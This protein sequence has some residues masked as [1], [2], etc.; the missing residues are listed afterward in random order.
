MAEGSQDE[1]GSLFEGMVL[2]TPQFQSND[3]DDHPT[4]P[5]PPAHP[6]LSPSVPRSS[7]SLNRQTS[8]P[9]DENLFSDLTLMPAPT[10]IQQVPL[11]SDAHNPPLVHKSTS[12]V[13]STPTTAGG[14]R[15][16]K[17]G[18]VRIGYARESSFT[19]VHLDPHPTPS[20]DHSSSLADV[21]A[22]AAAV[23]VAVAQVPASMSSEV[24]SSTP[25]APLESLQNV[26]S[27]GEAPDSAPVPSVSD[28][29]ETEVTTQGETE[30]IVEKDA[31]KSVPDD[32]TISERAVE[33]TGAE[34]TAEESGGGRSS[35][36]DDA[37]SFGQDPGFFEAKLE[38]I[39]VTIADSLERVGVS[40]ASAAA[41]RKE[42]ARR[43]RKAV[44]DVVV[45]TSK[46]MELEKE[47]EEA[48]EKEE[49][50]RAERVSESLAVAER[51]RQCCLD[52]LRE[53]EAQ[54]DAMY[55]KLQHALELQ[56]SAE[57]EGVS[58][59]EQFAED[60]AVTSDA[61]RKD[62]HLVYSNDMEDWLSSKEQLEVKK[63]EIEIETHLIDDACSSLNSSIDCLIEDD[64]KEKEVL[65]RKR[66]ELVEELEKLLALVRTKEAEIAECDAVIQVV[67]KRID[68][69]VSG[70]HQSQ[71]DIDRKEDKLK[72]ALHRITSEIEALE[73][74]KQDVDQFL[75]VAEEKTSKLNAIAT[76]A[77]EEARARSDLLHMRKSLSSSVLKSSAEK[78]RLVK[79]EE[80]I[81]EQVDALRQEISAARTSLQELSSKRA[82]IQQEVASS[83]LRIN[84]INRRGPELEAEKKVAAAA[85][86]FKEAGRIA[87]ESKALSLEKENL[88]KKIDDAALELKEA[89]EEIEQTTRKLRETE[90]TVLCKEKEAALARCK[91]LRLVAAEAMAERYSA[92]EMGDLDE[93]GS[94]LS[95]AEDADSEASKLQ[96]SYNFEG[97][98]FEKLDKKLISV[99]VIT[100][101]S[102][103]Q[104]AKVAASHLS[105]M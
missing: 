82:T 68:D 90:E 69:V 22:A 35:P 100:K 39:K 4:P 79:T 43:R 32:G 63:M 59:L 19:S 17:R 40:A 10:L 98:E 33:E 95:E 31:S 2:L 71:S 67:N 52:V 50:E 41:E 89:E 58:L 3:V 54:C 7:S 70:F 42:A 93:A 103:E 88:Q 105:A 87:A 27:D 6:Q 1:F 28:H 36:S 64:N 14:T 8:G 83:K 65:C 102:G 12:A 47:L 21:A 97:E 38:S 48:C 16:K 101:L 44:H 104:L 13:A 53:V 60:T 96:L 45:A 66:A 76:L 37:A 61:A 62:A 49:F 26:D 55:L 84:F 85:R 86:N 56:I 15:R 29:H 75:S 20:A 57:E 30:V 46:H 73:I 5:S 92:L 11:E 18:G 80:I 34:E 9:L 24:S 91:R 99:E 74:K 25:P 51:E 23:A 94:L 81:V 78:S 77:K 72:S